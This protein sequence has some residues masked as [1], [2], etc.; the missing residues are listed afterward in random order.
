MA[1]ISK[2]KLPDGVTYN[3]K[4]EVARASSGGGIKYYAS[5]ADLYAARTSHQ[6]GDVVIVTISLTNAVNVTSS[7][8]SVSSLKFHVG[9]TNL[10]S[11]KNIIVLGQ[12]ENWSGSTHRVRIIQIM[13]PENAVTAIDT[14]IGTVGSFRSSC[15]SCSFHTSDFGLV[16]DL[17]KDGTLVTSDHAIDSIYYYPNGIFGVFYT[18]TSLPAFD[19]IRFKNE[20]NSVAFVPKRILGRFSSSNSTYRMLVPTVVDGGTDD[21]MS[22]KFNNTSTSSTPYTMWGVLENCLP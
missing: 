17:Y 3:V 10:S 9:N 11:V 1:D 8:F 14:D 4:D 7:T 21:I 2:I 16:V 12:C 18:G 22:Y 15:T 6:N 20:G 5:P 13:I 19:E